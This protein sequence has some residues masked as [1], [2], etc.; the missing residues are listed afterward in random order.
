[1]F[2]T[3]HL[4]ILHHVLYKTTITKNLIICAKVKLRKNNKKRTINFSTSMNQ[5]LGISLYFNH[6]IKI[7]HT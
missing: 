6:Y 4:I 1:M 3:F 5:N 7:I 2:T